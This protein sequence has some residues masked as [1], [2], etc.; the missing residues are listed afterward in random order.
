METHRTS[1]RVMCKARTDTW[2]SA[3]SMLFPQRLMIHVRSFSSI[4]HGIAA[5]GPKY[6]GMNEDT[7]MRQHLSRIFTVF[8]MWLRDCAHVVWNDHHLPVRCPE[9]FSPQSFL[10][11]PTVPV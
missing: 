10:G 9:N 6:D 2:T 7:D 5:G 3:W 11:K 8:A 4:G 1:V